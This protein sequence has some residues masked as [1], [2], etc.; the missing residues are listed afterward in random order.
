VAKLV[1][2]KAERDV[3]IRALEEQLAA[4]RRQLRRRS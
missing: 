3:R 2:E 4:L 1:Q